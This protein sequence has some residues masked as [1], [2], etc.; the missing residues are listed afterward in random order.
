MKEKSNLF[1]P[2]SGMMIEGAGIEDILYDVY[3]DI[4]CIVTSSSNL[5]P[6]RIDHEIVR[7]HLR[8]NIYKS[9]I[10]DWQR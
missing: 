3:T 9:K 10:K 4:Y 2:K 5:Y 6:K 8:T 7:E 1:L